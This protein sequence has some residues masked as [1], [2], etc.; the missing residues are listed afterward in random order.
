MITELKTMKMISI[1]NKITTTRIMMIVTKLAMTRNMN[2]KK[3]NN[4]NNNNKN[5][6][7]SNTNMYNDKC[8]HHYIRDGSDN[9]GQC[10]DDNH[11]NYNNSNGDKKKSETIS[12]ESKNMNNN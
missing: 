7:D 3:N 1:T 9:Y 4:N 8:D 2:D 5:N 11:V 10:G 6:D 12:N